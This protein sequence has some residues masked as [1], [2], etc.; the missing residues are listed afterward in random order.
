MKLL[1]LEDNET[2]GIIVRSLLRQQG[3]EATW[4][5][6][7]ELALELLQ[8]DHPE[9]VLSDLHLVGSDSGDDLFTQLRAR[10]PNTAL[11]AYSGA[12][13]REALAQVDA[14]LP[15]DGLDPLTLEFVLRKALQLRTEI[16]ALRR[17]AERIV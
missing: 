15:K 12:P 6:S 1:L 13:P 17:S 11:V 9:V 5:T 3:I 10:L 14:F 8:D 7:F 16:T 2:D 4:A